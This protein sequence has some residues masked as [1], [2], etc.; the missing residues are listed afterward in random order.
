MVDAAVAA[1]GS[2]MDIP[3][4]MGSRWNGSRAQSVPGVWNVA[5]V[6][7]IH[8]TVVVIIAVA[9]VNL[10]EEDSNGFFLGI[11]T[12]IIISSSSI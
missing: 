8:D 5:V 9:I 4:G 6:V 12:I 3:G 7:A 2:A 1:H 11:I 10:I